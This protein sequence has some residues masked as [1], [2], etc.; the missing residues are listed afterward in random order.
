MLDRFKNFI[1]DKKLFVSKDKL[2]L[3]VSGGIDSVVLAHLCHE[4]GL[5]FGIAHCNFGLRAEESEGDEKFV[6]QLSEKFKVPFYSTHFNTQAFADEQSIS[7]QMAARQLRYKW[8]EEIRKKNKYDLVLI[9]HHK[10]DEI[11]TLF[12]N[13]IRGTGIS[14]LHGIPLQRGKIVRP[15]L[16]ATRN[17]IE[18]Y[19]LQNNLSFREDSS[20]SSDKYIRNKLRQKVIPVLK[21]INSSLE[22][23]ISK[24]IERLQQ[25]EQVYREAVEQKIKSLV[26]KKKNTIEVDVKKL[27]KL[28]PV[29][30]YIYELLKPF[31]FNEAVCADVLGVIKDKTSGRQFFSQTHRLLKDRSKLIITSHSK[32]AEE[33][34]V[35]KAGLKKINKP[36]AMSISQVKAASYTIPRSAQIASV[37]LGKLKFPLT[38]R[39][40]KQGDAFRPLGM[41]T[42]KKLSDFFIDNKFSLIDKENTWLLL[43]G[44]DIVWV[45]GHRV[46]DRYKVTGKTRVVYKLAILP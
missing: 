36:F 16:F 8:F 2:L 33:E 6:K 10:D 9:A 45:I 26:V 22:A 1:N 30:V 35:I 44:T 15:L 5:K 18:Q 34:F 20:N 32:G 14:G 39:K 42:K 38:I 19:V 7:I 4:A 28:Y 27:L 13:L 43:S 12:I 46:D 23:T 29:A 25:V 37:D 31:G 3:A 21:E 17:E 40:W 11:E 41:T 24:N